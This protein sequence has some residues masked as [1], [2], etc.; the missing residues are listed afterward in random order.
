MTRVVEMLRSLGGSTVGSVRLQYAILVAGI[1]IV[2]VMT[3]QTAGN[4]VA[5]KLAAVTSALNRIQF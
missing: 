3:A 5:E 4:K 1:A 2:T